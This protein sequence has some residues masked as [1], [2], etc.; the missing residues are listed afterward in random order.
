MFKV[1]PLLSVLFCK[2]NSDST[3]LI[4]QCFSTLLLIQKKEKRVPSLCGV[5]VLMLLLSCLLVFSLVVFLS[6]VHIVVY[7]VVFFSTCYIHVCTL[8]LLSF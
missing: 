6:I 2:T 4:L 3:W 5:V 1:I 8:K 7:I